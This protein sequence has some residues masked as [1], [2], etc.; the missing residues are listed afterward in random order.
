MTT[1]TPDGRVVLDYTSRDY[2][3]IRAMLV[4]LAQGF[5]PEWGTVGEAGDF[6]TLLLELFAYSGDVLNYYI[7]RIGAEAFLGTAAR[8]Q[9]VMYIADMLGYVPIGQ[10]SATVPVKFTWAWDGAE[11]LIDVQAFAV[12]YVSIANNLVTMHL[13]NPDFSV[14][15]AAGQTITVTGLDALEING[16]YVVDTA[17]PLV[18]DIPYALTFILPEELA[19]SDTA[20]PITSFTTSPQVKTGSTI[21]IP[22]GTLLFS[23]PD[24]SGQA[25]VF[26]T[27][28]DVFLDSSLKALRPTPGFVSSVEVPNDPSTTYQVIGTATATEGSTVNPSQIG[29][30]KGI[31]SAEMVLPD[32]GIVNDSVQ[33]FT[34]EGGQAIEWTRLR[35]LAI[36]HPTQSAFAMYVDDQDLT[37]IVFG[38]NASGRVPPVN[39]E[40]HVGY[41]VGVGAKANRL[42]VGAVT[43]MTNDFASGMGVTVTST[44]VP[45]GGLDIE[46][47][48]S[49]RFSIPRANA[50]RQRAVNLDDY[51]ALALQVPGVNK[52]TAYGD[53]YTEV[54][55]RVAASA[56][57]VDYQ[58]DP[59]LYMRVKTGLTTFITAKDNSPNLRIGQTVYVITHAITGSFE[60]Q[61]LWGSNPTA[62]VP[63]S[64]MGMSNN[65][66]TLGT[67]TPHGLSVGQPFTV[68]GLPVLGDNPNVA[69]ILNGTWLV[70]SVIDA[71]HFK[72]RC[73]RTQDEDAGH[74]AGSSYNQDFARRVIT[75]GT[76]T[77]VTAPGVVLRTPAATVPTVLNNN[78]DMIGSGP[79]ITYT[80]P[81]M[82]VLIE[83]TED[84]L[85]D[86]TLIG[87]VTFAEPVVW[88]DIDIDVSITVLP[89]Y[90]RTQ[91]ANTVKAAIKLVLAFDT[92]DFGQ[93]I[94]S[95]AIHRAIL[96]IDGVDYGSINTLALK[97]GSGSGDI[98]TPKLNLPRITPQ[99]LKDDVWIHSTGGLSGT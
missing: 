41:R 47:T 7:D 40:I 48:E 31:P 76:G 79:G 24:T 63:V 9:S 28:Y 81:A 92:V 43:N 49:M 50:L 13:S 85:S 55:V 34:K 54:Y 29:I 61:K 14:D 42:A 30:S 18:D 21:I 17:I 70:A 35:S 78:L 20:S 96:T 77:I 67:S 88:T 62:T 53:N 99:I 6:G 38:D 51:K 64:S 58:R 71:N 95:G 25:V 23:D 91:V 80:D 90:N 19:V 75:A 36:A 74:L 59:I 82:Q 65:L 33:V 15:I 22:A 2:K 87:S 68:T 89:L 60:V 69:N 11:T 44:A 5:L 52:A 97:G 56:D 32:I 45:T 39:A 37:H 12:S 27:D 1:T 86:K 84:Y 3:S 66:A 26:E 83:A 46:S 98:V 73:M 16:S 57:S 10:T 93:R 8:R 94:S 4:G 72:Y